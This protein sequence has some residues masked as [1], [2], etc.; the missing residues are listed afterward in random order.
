MELQ[1]E[2]ILI[3][4]LFGE[5]ANSRAYMRNHVVQGL[6]PPLPET[7]GFRTDRYARASARRVPDLADLSFS[8]SVISYGYLRS[9]VRYNQHKFF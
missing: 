3:V 5:A 8:D 9:K 6:R 1:K 7:D 4:T 2:K